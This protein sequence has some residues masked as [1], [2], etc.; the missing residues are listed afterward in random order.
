MSEESM[1][2]NIIAS[3]FLE[4]FGSTSTILHF[5]IAL[6]ALLYWSSFL[7]ADKDLTG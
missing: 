5:S 6:C 2:K 4:A 3:H 1:K 7:V